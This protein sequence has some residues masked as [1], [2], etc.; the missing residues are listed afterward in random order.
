MKKRVSITVDNRLLREVDEMVDGASVKSRS[1]AMEILLR[2]AM[3]QEQVTQAL[4]LAGGKGTRLRPLT[5]ELPKPL[6]PLAGKPIMEH[7]LNRLRNAGVRDILVSVGHKAEKVISYFGDGSKFGVKITYVTEPEPMGTGGPLALAT[8]MLDMSFLMLNGDVVT[9]IDFQDLV[10]FHRRTGALGTIALF[11]VEDPSR[12][13]AVEIV[14]NKIARFIEKPEKDQSQSKLINAGIYVL[15]RDILKHVPRGSCLI[16][17]VFSQLAPSGA[18]SGY[19][20]GGEKAYWRDIG[21]EKSYA[22]VLREV[23]KGRLDWL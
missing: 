2:R 22:S 8:N 23:K 18:L 19:V 5:Y 14:G 20:H 17:D 13:G 7:L 15:N 3:N 12:F 11:Q 16:E 10:A 21:T 6:F 1:H 9:N 4:I